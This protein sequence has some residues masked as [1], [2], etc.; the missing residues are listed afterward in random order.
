M[1]RRTALG[2]IGSALA[3]PAAAQT[4][5]VPFAAETAGP[6]P[7]NGTRAGG[8]LNVLA[9]TGVV[10]QDIRPS[11]AGMTGSATGVPLKIELTLRDTA[12]NCAAMAGA[13]VYAWHC[14][15]VGNYSLYSLPDQNYLRGV[16][17]AD[18]DGRLSFTTIYPGCYPGRA[19]H[20]HFEV[21]ASVEDA[22]AA[23]SS[24]LT[25][26]F[27]FSDATSEKVYRRDGYGQSLAVFRDVPLSRD[28]V[29]RD[30]TRAEIAVMTFE[31]SGDIATGLTARALVGVA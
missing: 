1:T 12:N 9:K 8:G 11:F 2:F 7:A 10:R 13:A 18:T 25:S 23:R 16:Q 22:A 24:R 29:F 28:G 3:L 27:V 26:Q 21:F 15:A 4:C 19:P 5:L 17:I 14:D 6:F 20:I 31:V 30:N